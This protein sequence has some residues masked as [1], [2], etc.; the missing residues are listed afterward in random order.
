MPRMWL[1]PSPRTRSQT[2]CRIS[3][4]SLNGSSGFRLSLSVNFSPSS[5]GQKVD[6][7]TP[8]GLN[9]TTSRCLR[10][11]LIGEA[12]ARQVQHERQRRRADAQVAEKLA[13]RTG[14]GRLLVGCDKRQPQ[15]AHRLSPVSWR[16]AALLRR[17]STLRPHVVTISTISWRILNSLSANE[18]L[19]LRQRLRAR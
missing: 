13:S 2:P 14:H 10:G 19:Q 15:P 18:L 16:R 12:Q 7:T 3:V 4:R 9:M 11:L 5:S 8:L 17:L 6:G 1:S